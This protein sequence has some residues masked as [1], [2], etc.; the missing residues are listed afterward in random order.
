MTRRQK[1]PRSP[2]QQL[3]AACQSG[4]YAEEIQALLARHLYSEADLSEALETL[5]GSASSGTEN[6]LAKQNIRLIERKL[7]GMKLLGKIRRS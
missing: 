4:G 2:L 1:G 3:L 5:A 7:A 6:H